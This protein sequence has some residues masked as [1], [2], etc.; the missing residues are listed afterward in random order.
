MAVKKR[1]Q[2]LTDDEI[3]ELYQQPTFGQAERE[4]Y[5]F[6]DDTMLREVRSITKVETRIYF[7]LLTGYF[8][9][10]PVVPRF[11]LANIKADVK[12]I[13]KHH[14]P[15]YDYNNLPPL[16]SSTHSRIANKV[17]K[18]SGFREL[19]PELLSGLKQRLL[20]VATIQIDPKYVFDECLAY[21]GQQH[22]PLIAYSSLQKII[23]EV[24][25]R[26]RK[27]IEQ[28]LEQSVSKA[29]LKELSRILSEPAMLNKL[30]GYKSMA[31]NFSASELKREMNVH[32]TVKTLYPDIKQAVEK[33]GLSR[34]N[35]MYYA[36]L[37]QQRSTYKLR[38][39]NKWQSMLYLVCY[40][41]FRYRQ[42]NDKLITAFC[43]LVNKHNEVAKAFANAK[44][45]Q[46]L[47][48]VRGS[49]SRT[50]SIL[51]LFIDEHVSDNTAF[52]E[53]RKQAFSLIPEEDVRIISQYLDKNDFDVTGYAWEYT[54]SR[55][56]QTAQTLR[57]LFKVIDIDCDY[58]QSAL[59]E[60][61]IAAKTELSK[62]KGL[63]T[64]TKALIKPKDKPY[65]IHDGEVNKKR[66][67]FYLYNRIK[68]GLSSEKVFI[69]ESEKNKRLE[70][71]LIPKR[72][73]QQEQDDLIEKT[74]LEKLRTPIEKT[75]TD[76]HQKLN[77]QLNRIKVSINNDANEF[78]R[79]EKGT[80]ELT[81]KL[82]NQRSKFNPENPVYNQFPQS[83][84][85]DVMNFTN[86]HTG[87]LGAFE[88]ISV[89]KPSSAVSDEDLIACIFGNG[90][91][92]GLY[93]IAS[94][95]DRSVGALRAVNDSYLRPETLKAANDV[96]SNAIGKLPIFKYYNIQEDR[97][98]GSIDAQ[99][100]RCRINTFK[101]RFSAKHFRKGKGVSAISMVVNHVPVNAEV[102]APNEY[103]GHFVFDL[104]FN[105]SSE[106][107]PDT[108][109]TDTHGTNSVNFA[110]LDIFGYQFAPRYARF[111]SQFE[112][113]FDISLTGE[114]DIRL[115][116]PINNK[117]I[118]EEWPQIQH[119]ICSLSRKSTV[120]GTIIKKL[121][122]SK[123]SSRTLSALREYDRLIKCLYLL[124]YADNKTLRQFVQQTLNRGE[125]Y[126]QLRKAIGSI[127]GNQFKGG[128]DYQVNQWNDCARLIA[129]CIIYY[130]SVILSELVEQFEQLGNT[131]AVSLLANLSPVAWTHIQLAG[132]YSFARKQKPLNLGQLLENLEPLF[133][134]NESTTAD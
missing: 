42:T 22:I 72:Q 51:N 103:E 57:K 36:S 60:Q 126:H 12:Y 55:N 33:L 92:Y 85:V 30:S 119:I 29:T 77:H 43:Y 71:D 111:K 31:R 120:Q 10:K 80:T 45:A 84:I 130:N 21:F 64:L 44:L 134:L 113:M 50:G 65:L 2:I 52:G 83:S 16:S 128:S 125:A 18:L 78:V 37:I 89:R 100:L 112:N 108:I 104:L 53:V 97:L 107:Q 6:L 74:G 127:N 46:E 88:N 62:R 81:W 34:G 24:L 101:A 32:A 1:I 116:K 117:L 49:L 8:Q 131:Q 58:T 106:L 9:Y 99:K 41:Y 15:D 98:F 25:T 105:N 86:T 13:C 129:N 69:S 4:E 54:E 67:E 48:V 39:T 56:A 20:D 102:I 7:I 96:I 26:E 38:R 66:F 5:F 110:L 75:L 94:A 76:L 11:K 122:T 115:K 114:L 132:Y 14:F 121:A 73:W 35:M 87:F 23:S 27:R 61:I 93:K 124:E 109:S 133:E 63:Q 70:H 79:F 28:V 90:A 118:I 40:L 17:I 91:N 82:A 68:D 3:N 95:S 47:E 19:T 59:S 123:R